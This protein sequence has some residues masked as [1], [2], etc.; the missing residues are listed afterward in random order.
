MAKIQYEVHNFRQSTLDVIAQADRIIRSYAAQ[1]YQLTLRQLYYQFVSRDIIPNTQKDYSRLGDIVSKARRAGMLDWSAIV[2][3]TRNLET[4]ATW[5]DASDIVAAIAAQFRVDRWTDQPVYVEIWFEKDALIG[6]FERPAEA[7]RV[8]YFSCRGYTSDSEVWGAAQR[9]QRKTA[10]RTK[11]Q[12]R[13]PAVILHFGD[14]DPSGL[15]MT[16][17]IGDRLALF[18]ARVD[19][20]RLALN[21]DQVEQYDP[22]PNPAKETDSRFE[23]YRAEY[24]DESWE[25]DALEPTVLAKLVTDELRTLVDED[26]WAEDVERETTTRRE[27]RTVSDNYDDVVRYVEDTHGLL[28]EDPADRDD[29]LADAKA[30]DDDDAE[31]D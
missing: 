18:G 21:M 16:R 2:D 24:G 26:Q 3:R 14:H 9:F 12:K 17:D 30:E 19:V 1:G 15:D 29:G 6:V 31:A 4:L 7:L 13:R 25:L 11:G 27:L 8:P 23:N 10:P 20:R 28:D 5:S 22:P